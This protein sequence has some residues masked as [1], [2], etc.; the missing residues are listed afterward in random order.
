MKTE[1]LTSSKEQIQE[2]FIRPSANRYQ[3]SVVICMGKFRDRRDLW[4]LLLNGDSNNESWG[5]DEEKML[6]K[7]GLRN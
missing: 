1:L 5:L 2:A 3:P 4:M 6:K 7:R